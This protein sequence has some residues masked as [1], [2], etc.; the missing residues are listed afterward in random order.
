LDV[1][2][3]LGA[4]P[5]GAAPELP[6]VD[7]SRDVLLPEVPAPLVPEPVPLELAPDEPAVPLLPPL[8]WSPHAA[9]ARAKIPAAKAVPM[10]FNVMSCSSG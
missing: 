4:V 6:L 3:S 8:P 5:P 2:E 1:L 10:V 9:R 7:L